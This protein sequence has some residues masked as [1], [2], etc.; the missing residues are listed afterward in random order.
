MMVPVTPAGRHARR[1]LSAATEPPASIGVKDVAVAL[2]GGRRRI[3][4]NKVMGAAFGSAA[5]CRF[6]FSSDA[7]IKQYA[8]EVLA[9]QDLSLPSM[10]LDAST[11][12]AVLRHAVRRA[13]KPK[14]RH[15]NAFAV[16]AVLTDLCAQMSV[17]DVDELIAVAELR[18]GVRPV[19]QSDLDAV[20]DQ[21]TTEIGRFAMR[22]IM[23]RNTDGAPSRGLIEDDSAVLDAAFELASMRMLG[24]PPGDAELDIWAARLAR[25]MQ[26]VALDE[27]KAIV[28]NPYGYSISALGADAHRVAKVRAASAAAVLMCLLASEAL[29]VLRGAEQLARRRGFD[30][31][32]LRI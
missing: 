30:P 20:L 18:S 7:E 32:Q 6:T 28:R 17:S 11:I 21:L 2:L 10:L 22:A 27:I 9:R 8:R 19:D 16:V 24:R 4:L 14:K 3:A 1:L 29:D 15:K 26:D 31:E 13:D 23:A 25:L 5:R 12:G